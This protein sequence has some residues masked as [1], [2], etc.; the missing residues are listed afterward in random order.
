MASGDEISSKAENAQVS[1]NGCVLD[2][3]STGSE[4]LV[5]GEACHET[6]SRVPVSAGSLTPL[7]LWNH[8]ELGV[9]GLPGTGSISPL[10]GHKIHE[11]EPSALVWFLCTRGGFGGSAVSGDGLFCYALM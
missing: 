10:T 4:C 9:V 5:L 2:P 6:G 7:R 1:E 11:C 8:C 3:S